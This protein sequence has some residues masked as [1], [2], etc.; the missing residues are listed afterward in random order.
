[1]VLGA[2]GEHGH[3]AGMAVVKAGV[4]HNM[5]GAVPLKDA[6]VEQDVIPLQQPA[7]GGS[8]HLAVEA[9]VVGLAV[10]GE[11]L[12][13]GA[14]VTLGGIGYRFRSFGTLHRTGRFQ[15]W[16]FGQ[17]AQWSEV[18]GRDTQSFL[19]VENVCDLLAV[20]FNHH[21]VIVG[22]FLGNGFGIIGGRWLGQPLVI[23]SG[24]TPQHSGVHSHLSATG[25]GFGQAM[26]QLFE[27]VVRRDPFLK[28][29]ESQLEFGGG[30]RAPF[31]RLGQRNPPGQMGAR[32]HPAYTRR[33]VNDQLAAVPR[34]RRHQQNDAIT[35]V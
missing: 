26:H 14:V 1:M 30:M 23:T 5:P 15:H 18:G 3:L 24:R 13:P 34:G 2:R 10:G 28:P 22:D 7:G 25:K 27:L 20:G 16:E 6:L 33:N 35:P 9:A 31:Y 4:T 29:R 21:S 17:L 8:V 11:R 19:G 12:P 32:L